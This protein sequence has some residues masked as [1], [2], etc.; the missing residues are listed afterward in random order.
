MADYA[1]AVI[2]GQVITLAQAPVTGA[3]GWSSF[4]FDF[5]SAGTHTL[6][7][8]VVDVG[9]YD[10]TSTLAVDD[11][12]VAPVPEPATVMLM[13]SGLGLLAGWRRRRG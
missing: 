7:F 6:G 11:V 8:G 12:R 13:L 1:F 2:D 10:L 3:T 4:S 5:A 9:D